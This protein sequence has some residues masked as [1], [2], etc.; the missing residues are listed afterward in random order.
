MNAGTLG[1]LLLLGVIWGAWHWPI[2]LM[3]Y[4][5]PGHPLLGIVLMTLYTT[6]LA[7]VLGYAVLRSGSVLQSAYLHGLNNQVVAYMVAIGLRPFDAAFA[8][9]IGTYGM[10]TLA[11]VAAL[12]LCDPIWR[13][14]GGSLICE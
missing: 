11:V 10:I 14:R 8:F 9:G 2:I 4:N 7:V 5:Y 1:G 3:G 6:G 12:I 13:G